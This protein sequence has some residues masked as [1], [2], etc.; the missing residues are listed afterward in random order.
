MRYLTLSQRAA[1]DALSKHLGVAHVLE[2]LASEEHELYYRVMVRWGTKNHG[3]NL[4]SQ[5]D[6]EIFYR[7]LDWCFCHDC[8]VKLLY[9]VMHGH[10]S[11]NGI[12]EYYLKEYEKQLLS[13]VE[14]YGEGN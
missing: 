9:A 11:E 8:R 5:S 14:S 2:V 6:L 12:T 7:S 3:S 10:S 1:M 13:E 4:V